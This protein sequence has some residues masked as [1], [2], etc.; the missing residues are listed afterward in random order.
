MDAERCEPSGSWEAFDGRRPPHTRPDKRPTGREVHDLSAA[1]AQHGGHAG[2]HEEGEMGVGTQ[3]PI[4]HQHISLLSAWMH[5]L[6]LGE[7]VGEEGR[8][9]QLQEHPGARM[10]QPQEPRDGKTAPRPLHVRLAEG[11]LE[12]RRI[13]HRA[14]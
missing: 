10:K 4:G 2:L 3:A 12:G 5:R 9:H 7:I 14:A 6:H 8:G 1:D 13:G 11:V